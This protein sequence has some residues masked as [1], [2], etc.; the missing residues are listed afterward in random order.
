MKPFACEICSKSFKRKDNMQR[1]V[2]EVHYGKKRD[3][4]HNEKNG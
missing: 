4:K 3:V 1:H 2:K